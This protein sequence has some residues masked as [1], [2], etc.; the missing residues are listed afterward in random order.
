MKNENDLMEIKQGLRETA[1]PQDAAGKVAERTIHS[2]P[3]CI[4]RPF[5]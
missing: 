1:E 4:F 3:T 2:L 5:C